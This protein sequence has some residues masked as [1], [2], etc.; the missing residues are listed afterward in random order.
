[1]HTVR[2]GGLDCVPGALSLGGDTHGGAG[3]VVSTLRR[4]SIFDMFLGLR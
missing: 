4:P 3:A 2:T 1:M